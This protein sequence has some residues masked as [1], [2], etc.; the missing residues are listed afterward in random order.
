MKISWSTKQQQLTRP[1]KTGEAKKNLTH[2]F[3]L[4]PFHR[5]SSASPSP[6]LFALSLP[7]FRRSS[8]NQPGDQE[9]GK[10]RRRSRNNPRRRQHS[11]LQGRAAKKAGSCFQTKKESGMRLRGCLTVCVNNYRKKT[12]P[13]FAVTKFFLLP[14]IFAA[15]PEVVYITVCST[16]S[17][18][19]PHLPLSF[20]GSSFP[21]LSFFLTWI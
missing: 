10:G 9:V 18:F 16:P 5:L 11:L 7:H 3:S 20:S 14:P 15:P 2:T 21:P 6:F 13:L 17:F 19:P 4:P 12:M 8:T 1:G